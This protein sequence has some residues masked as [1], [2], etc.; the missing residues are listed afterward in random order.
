M[1]T[2]L[3]LNMKKILIVDFNGTAPIYTHYFSQGLSKSNWDVKILGHK[4]SEHLNFSSTLT[5]YIGTQIF[6]KSIN[7]LINW[8]YLLKICKKYDIINIQWFQ[9]LNKTGL[10]LYLIRILKFLNP[11]IYYTVHNIYPH[12]CI[13]K[14]LLKRYNRLYQII[15]NFLIHT[16]KSKKQIQDIVNTKKKYVNINHGY[17]YNEFSEDKKE[18]SQIKLLMIG[19]ISKYKGITDAIKVVSILKKDNYNVILSIKGL[20]NNDKDY[21]NEIHELITELDLEENVLIEN[22]FITTTELVHA[23]Q[24]A[25]F[26]IMPY[27]KIEQSGVLFTSLGLGTPVVAYDIGGLSDIII[28][29]RNG[30]LARQNDIDDLSKGIIN[31]LNNY[32]MIKTNLSKGSKNNLWVLNGPIL[33][34][35]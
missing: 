4:N 13:N 33:N 31:C 30:Y 28:S 5:P 35:I 9:M 3:L 18:F 10:E 25:T 1:E 12:N 24:S 6:G 23:Y 8:I 34:E 7:Y 21:L 29:G 19:Y 22:K 15:D 20:C 17:F 27:K 26:S 14:K 11:N 2:S 32:E 16:Q